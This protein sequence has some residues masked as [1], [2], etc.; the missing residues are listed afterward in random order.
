VLRRHPEQGAATA[1]AVVANALD[2]LTSLLDRVLPMADEIDRRT[3]DFTRRSLARF[4]Y[5]QEVTGE[6]R[7]EM[8]SFFN[9]I[10]ALLAGRKFAAAV[11]DLPEMPGFLLPEVKLPAGLDSLYAPPARRAP[12]DQDAFDDTLDEGDRA[13]GLRGMESALRDALSVQ[14]ANAFVAGLPGGKGVRVSSAEI[15]I[16]GDKGFSDLISLLLHA[17]SAEA[18]YRVEVDRV[19]DESRPPSL[20]PLA[21]GATE[22]FGIIKK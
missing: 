15:S 5:L 18:R 21:G 3:A 13:D 22:R 9:Q 10:N 11:G 7:S 12:L 4:R 19:V 8:K 6:R 20:D 16:E 17:E 14:R 1:R 2:D